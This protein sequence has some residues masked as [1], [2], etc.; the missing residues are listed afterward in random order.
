MDY[1]SQPLTIS[2]LTSL[3]VSSIIG[4]LSLVLSIRVGKDRADRSALRATYQMLHQH[5][6]EM[7]RRFIVG[8]PYK[9]NEFPLHRGGF[10]P[11]A[12]DLQRTG[13]VNT[14]PSHL[15]ET[16]I[17]VEREA[18]NRGENFREAVDGI[19]SP[20]VIKFTEAAIGGKRAINA[21]GSH[22]S[23]SIP[24][25]VMDPKG[26]A[27][28]LMKSLEKDGG[29][30]QLGIGTKTSSLA[31]LVVSKETLTDLNV[32]QFLHQLS[33]LAEDLGRAHKEEVQKQISS[34]DDTLRL[35]ASRIRDP[36][37]FIETLSSLHR[38]LFDQSVR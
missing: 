19:V 36:H 33:E 10:Y 21:I 25:L 32:E 20:A 35:L 22:Y 8:E 14:L 9:W 24:S 11:P 18:L 30:S 28:R 37:P 2:L 23:L 26:T 38:D 12:K 13:E 7:R 3:I 16:L 17:R 29:P 15:A 6:T 27:E 1:F 31:V 34:I 4:I 5:F